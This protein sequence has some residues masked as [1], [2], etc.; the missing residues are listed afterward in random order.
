MGRF[1]RRFA[2]AMATAFL[3]LAL[4][5]APSAQAVQLDP[6]GLGQVLI[7]PYYTVHD[8]QQT[9]LSITNT[10]DFE[11]VVQVTLREALNGRPALQFKVWLGRYDVWTGTLYAL[12]DDGMASDGAGIATADRSCTTPAFTSTGLTTSGGRPYM[13]L[14]DGSY[15][16]AM[17]DGG[18]SGL[19]RARHGWIEVIT[20]ANLSGP[21]AAAITHTTNGFPASCA[22]VQNLPSSA[23]GILRPNGGMMGSASV[24]RAGSGTLLSSRAEALS[25]FTETSLFYDATQVAPDL[26]SVNQGVSGAAVSAK[27]ID[28]QGRWQ[29]LTYGQSGSGSRPIDAVSAVLMASRVKNEYRAAVAIGDAT[30]WVLT[31]PTK[32]FYTDPAI[33]GTGSPALAP[34]EEPFGAPGNSRLCAPH[35]LVD[36]NQ[37]AFTTNFIYCE[38]QP[39]HNPPSNYFFLF[40][41]ANVV[42]FLG[43]S[44][45][46]PTRTGVLAAPEP[47]GTS[48][49]FFPWH[50]PPVVGP[51]GWMDVNLAA[52][53]HRLP[54]SAEGKILSGIPVIGYSAT[55]IANSSRIGSSFTTSRA[56]SPNAYATRHATTVACTKA[57]GGMP[58]D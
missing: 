13:P 19:S 58:C 4:L 3:G 7:Y 6:G 40:Q 48:T 44:T 29:V 17:S 11:Q 12:A 51:A 34:F 14:L 38:P 24:V 35:R 16:G 57:T 9:V 47:A 10:S 52:R 45:A 36:Q 5:P 41:A 22:M 53:S 49:P 1:E 31:L 30:D 37:K 8:R 54:A 26:A 18:P 15:S 33:V 21:I 55:T 23:A 56:L 28:S 46:S 25:G 43:S 2:I 20:L 42:G 27:I 50:A 39:I 32:R